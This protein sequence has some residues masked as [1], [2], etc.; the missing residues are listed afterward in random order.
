MPR[1]LCGHDAIRAHLAALDAEGARIELFP[2]V[3]EPVGSAVLVAGVLRIRDRSS[4]R[5]VPRWW[6]HDVDGGQ[7]VALRGYGSREQALAAV[8]RR[9]RT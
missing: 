9:R 4:W 7:I 6:L 5:D 2:Y 8:S 1:T 3:F